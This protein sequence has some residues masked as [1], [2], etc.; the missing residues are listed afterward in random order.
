M[1]EVLSQVGQGGGRGEAHSRGRR[2]WRKEDRRRMS[3]GRE[4]E[5]VKGREEGRRGDA[6]DGQGGT[7][8]WKDRRRRIMRSE[9]VLCGREEKRK[10]RGFK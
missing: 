2:G 1:V 5:R 3:E 9:C 10:T 4:R 8:R 6:G 7:Q